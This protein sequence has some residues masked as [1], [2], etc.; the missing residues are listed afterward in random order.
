MA[1]EQG[2]STITEEH[3]RSRFLTHVSVTTVLNQILNE[4]WF[5]TQ[6]GPRPIKALALE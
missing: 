4:A 1:T 5:D 3:S 6:M 2:D